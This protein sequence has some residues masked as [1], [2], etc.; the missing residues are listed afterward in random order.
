MYGYLMIYTFISQLH[1]L[2]EL[3]L[4][5]YAAIPGLSQPKF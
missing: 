2:Y 1:L 4:K 5:S 3:A